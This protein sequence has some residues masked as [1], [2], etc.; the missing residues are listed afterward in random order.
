MAQTKRPHAGFKFQYAAKFICTA[1]IPGTSQRSHFPPGS[2]QTGVNIHNPFE[3]TIKL[4]MKIAQPGLI[5]K[6]ISTKL[7]GDEVIRITCDEISK[8]DVVTIHGFEGFL[9][10]ESSHSLDVTAVYTA[11]GKNAYVVS[12]D[13]EEVGERL[14]GK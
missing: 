9:V 12:I 4:R 13:V 1:T 6:W 7:K 8:F 14:L 10:I 2:Y 3:R 11:S 5:S